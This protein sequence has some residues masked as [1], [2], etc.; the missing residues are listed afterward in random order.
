MVL[1]YVTQF[2]YPDLHQPES[3]T[4]MQFFL[5]LR[6]LMEQCLYNEFSWRDL[7]MPTAKRLRIQLSALINLV[8]YLEGEQLKLFNELN[9]PVRDKTQTL[10]QYFWQTSLPIRHDI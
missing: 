4:E 3:F 5:A 10:V 6:Q 7:H 2:E 9:G 1:D 8:K